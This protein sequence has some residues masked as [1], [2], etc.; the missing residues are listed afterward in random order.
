ME[1]QTILAYRLFTKGMIAT[2]YFL[3]QLSSVSSTKRRKKR[4]KG[5]VLEDEREIKI[6]YSVE[7]FASLIRCLQAIPRTSVCYDDG[8]QGQCSGHI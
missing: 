8:R 7:A 1:D 6:E 4:V 3:L 2:N 5:K